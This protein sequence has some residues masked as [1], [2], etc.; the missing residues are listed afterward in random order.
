MQQ[1][2]F[3]NQS[4]SA[5]VSQGLFLFPS[6]A[7]TAPLLAEIEIIKTRAAFRQMKVPRGGL[8]S[9]AVTNV[10]SYGWVSSEAG[11]GYSTVDPLSQHPWPAIPKAFGDLAN[12][13]SELAGFGSFDPDAC[14]V[15]RYIAGAGMGLHQD[16]DEASFNHPIVSVSI[17]QSATFLWGGNERSHPV[18]KIVLN[19]GDVLVWGGV[20]RLNFHGV[21][22][23]SKRNV[24]AVRYNLTMRKAG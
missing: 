1:P 23:L 20:A 17:G 24:A 14:L 18:T 5:Q 19:D 3:A 4:E 21:V 13:A 10:G 2:L 6:F 7:P 16:K 8:M 9:V 11:Y 15:N 22:P 12:K